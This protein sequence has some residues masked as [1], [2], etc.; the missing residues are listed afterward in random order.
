MADTNSHAAAIHSFLLVVC[1][2]FQFD[3]DNSPAQRL[4]HT[5]PSDA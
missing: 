5:S 3:G 1:A 2:L 4:S